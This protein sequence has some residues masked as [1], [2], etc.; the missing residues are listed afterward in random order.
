MSSLEVEAMES[1]RRLDTAQRTA[2]L[3]ESRMALAR[4]LAKDR[5]LKG[6]Q[7]GAEVAEQEVQRLSGADREAEA[8]LVHAQEDVGK[9]EQ[10]LV[11]ARNAAGERQ[12]EETRRERDRQALATVLLHAEGEE[13][14]ARA[15]ADRAANTLARHEQRRTLELSLRKAEDELLQLDRELTENARSIE[16]AETEARVLVG[17]SLWLDKEELARRVRELESRS[18]DAGKLRR[19]AADALARAAKIEAE[20]ATRLPT[21]ERV[22]TIRRLADEREALRSKP[23]DVGGAARVGVVLP[24][25]IGVAAAAAVLVLL[26]LLASVEVQVIAVAGGGA[27]ALAFGVSFA[28]SRSLAM[29]TAREAKRLVEATSLE[30]NRRWRQEAEPYLRS[31][32][33][34]N[35]IALEDACAKAEAGR[36]DA[37]SFR[38]RAVEIEAQA[39]ERSEGTEL[40]PSARRDMET[41]LGQLRGHDE[42]EI[43]RAVAQA[44][45][46][47]TEIEKR[48]SAAEQGLARSRKTRERIL[49]SRPG[50]LSRCE[51]AKSL[52]HATGAK[53]QSEDEVRRL[54]EESGR[55]RALAHDRCEQIR[56][57]IGDHGTR[58]KG[59]LPD[60]EVSR[61]Q[62]ARGRLALAQE[63]LER[64]RANRDESTR[65][66]T[67]AQ[68]R[69]DAAVKAASAGDLAEIRELLVEAR[70]GAQLSASEEDELEPS[71]ATLF[72][73]RAR[74]GLMEAK[75][76]AEGARARLAE[77][78]LRRDQLRGALPEPWQAVEAASTDIVERA[79]AELALLQSQQPRE[80]EV[81]RSVF[82]LAEASYKKVE[83]ELIALQPTIAK[84]TV[85]RDTARTRFDQATTELEL[86]QKDAAGLDRARAEGAVALA[87]QAL[88]AIPPGAPVD[89]SALDAAERH[90]DEREQALTRVDGLLREVQGK[91]GLVGGAVVKDRLR[92][93]LEALERW[94]D[95][96]RKE[97]L[98]YAAA[99]LLRNVLKE[100]E[101]KHTAHLGK[102]LA[103]PVNDRLR[104]LTGS[105]YTEVDLDPNLKAMHVATHAGNR[106]WA[107]LS[108]GTREQV[109]TLMRLALGSCLKTSVLLDDQ[110]VQSDPVRLK[111]FR[112]A[113][114]RSSQEGDHQ[115][116]VITCRPHDYVGPDGLPV[117]NEAR[118]EYEGVAIV[119]LE[120]A[121]VRAP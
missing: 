18:D 92:E 6:A 23:V 98:D 5:A 109:A 22:D 58:K 99:R 51:T 44:R 75:G 63:A 4:L 70:P 96:E 121:V 47:R 108:V 71:S 72:L 114:A 19:S 8:A 90:L 86:R 85:A 7:R 68:A 33:V 31:A 95:R 27:G 116:I 2:D 20:L 38:A 41:L 80:D 43:A 30:I 57:Q 26:W 37:A 76:A 9:T 107:A 104:A 103:K 83:G 29:A 56:S 88:D 117:G 101:T 62:A 97:E 110:L 24:A 118:R 48:L 32:G 12:Q 120:K 1:G 42:D 113:L 59:A 10:D 111:W 91:L 36:K 55:Q 112:E 82:S 100:E 69:R 50:I 119:D 84:L 13:R 77:A 81:A 14:E 93:E 73:E 40:L 61:L 11:T 46:L 106:Q 102:L 49:E 60:D 89:R 74:T 17:A 65:K 52:L 66:L 3:A 78:V 28:V 115:I 39:R 64:A 79:K 105:R 45:S 35:V 15:G 67:Q 54:L 25:L 53:E 87:K 21:P 34:S 16:Q 94:Q